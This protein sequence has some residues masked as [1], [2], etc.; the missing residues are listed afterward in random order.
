[1]GEAEDEYGE[2]KII[3]NDKGIDFNDDS[4]EFYRKFYGARISDGDKGALIFNHKHFKYDN[5]EQIEVAGDVCF[6]LNLKNGKYY[7][8][9]GSIIKDEEEF[10]E[11][12]DLLDKFRYTP[13]NKSIMPKPGGLNNIKKYIG[14]D[15]FDILAWVIDRYY[16]ESKAL[17]INGNALNMTIKQRKKLEKFLDSY[18]NVNEYF[19]DIYGIDD[20]LINSLIK[21]GN[22]VIATK[23]QFY[24]YIGLA[25]RFWEKRMDNHAV[26]NYIKEQIDQYKND[27]KSIKD[28]INRSAGVNDI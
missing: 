18:E 6:N 19:K 7:T 11:L 1:M 3:M 20:D 4:K 23:E 2:R 24:N 16:S 17:I 27:L 28:I 22:E 8:L 14:N 13:M 12:G 9:L 5:E 25:L 21:S 26:Q 10:N 15:R